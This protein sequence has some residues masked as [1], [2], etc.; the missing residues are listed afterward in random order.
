MILLSPTWIF[1]G[2]VCAFSA[3][4]L[5]LWLYPKLASAKTGKR[6]LRAFYCARCG[7]VCVDRGEGAE[8]S[9]LQCGHLNQLK[10]LND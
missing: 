9:C 7:H 1:I 2:Y 6:E 5:A 4:A 3:L 8:V 10:T